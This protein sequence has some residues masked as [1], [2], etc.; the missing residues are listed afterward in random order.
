VR[1]VLIANRG[2][3]PPGI[4]GPARIRTRPR[5]ARA[6]RTRRTT[7]RRRAGRAIRRSHP[8]IRRDRP[9]RD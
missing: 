1:V 3:H 4:R 6:V 5:P 7:I 2:A 8:P 9:V